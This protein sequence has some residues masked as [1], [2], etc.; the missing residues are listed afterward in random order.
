MVC[1]C[2]HTTHLNIANSSKDD[3]SHNRNNLHARE[4]TTTLIATLDINTF[5]KGLYVYQDLWIPKLNKQL[6]ACMEPGNPKDKLKKEGR[7]RKKE[8]INKQPNEPRKLPQKLD[9]AVLFGFMW[10]SMSE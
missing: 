8:K 9:T 4:L 10:K 5:I 2:S 7:R 3:K 6:K 1:F